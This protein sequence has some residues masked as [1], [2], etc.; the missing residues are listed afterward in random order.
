MMS[1]DVV[2][3]R[4]SGNW[5]SDLLFVIGGLLRFVVIVDLYWGRLMMILCVLLCRMSLRS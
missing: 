4:W 2:F 3:V 1:L 5:V